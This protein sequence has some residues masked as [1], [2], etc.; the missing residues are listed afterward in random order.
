MRI[1]GLVIVALALSAI[2]AASAIAALPEAGR[3]VAKP[4]TGKYKDAGC[5][6]KAG[7]KATEKQ[8]EFLK[9]GV[10]VN[11]AGSGGESVLETA[12]GSKIICKSVAETG[13]YDL[14]T[15]IIKEVEGVV[16]AF[17]G[18]ELPLLIGGCETK[19]A[20]EGEILTSPLK[21]LLGYI[22]GKG[23]KSPVAGLQVTPESLK[24]PFLAFECGNG[25]AKVVLKQGAGKGGNCMIG[26]VSPA[27]TMTNTFEQVFSG[28]S[29]E[30][31]P[32]H[33][34]GST[35]LCNLEAATNGGKAERTALVFA[36]TVTNEETLEIKA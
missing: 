3:C 19:G 22:S 11:F 26:S 4:G 14:D 27:N 12:S 28:A 23:T 21:G 31:T 7:S 33:L 8:F 18:C 36:V 20:A 30:Q 15:G 6:E 25:A 29:G 10:L 32:Q 24:A 34:E 2:G 13:K 16:L 35:K 17:K 5:T 9:G 1:S